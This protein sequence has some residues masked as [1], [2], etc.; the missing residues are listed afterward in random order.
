MLMSL[1]PGLWKLIG[2]PV[3]D[4]LEQRAIDSVHGIS[5][6]VRRSSM[7]EAWKDPDAKKLIVDR[8]FQLVSIRDLWDYESC[9]PK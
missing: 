7:L 1:Q 5:E 4:T 3:R 2:H 8:K 6:A 9:K